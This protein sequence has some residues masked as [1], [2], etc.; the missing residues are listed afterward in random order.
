MLAGDL[1][2]VAGGRHGGREPGEG[3]AL[4][5]GGEVPDKREMDFLLLSY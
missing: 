5:L 1:V 2:E 3:E 4:V